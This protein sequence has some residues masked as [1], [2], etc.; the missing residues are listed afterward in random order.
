MLTLV[1]IIGWT[2][3]HS[4]PFMIQQTSLML[5]HITMTQSIIVLSEGASMM[6]YCKSAGRWCW[7]WTSYAQSRE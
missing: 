1:I 6:S 2:V 5:H 4:E 7:L 3:S